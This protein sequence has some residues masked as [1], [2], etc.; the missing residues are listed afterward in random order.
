[1]LGATG[2][3]H[4]VGEVVGLDFADLCTCLN[5]AARTCLAEC[6]CGTLSCVKSQYRRYQNGRG[7]LPLLYLY[8]GSVI[9]AMHCYI[10]SGVLETV[11]LQIRKDVKNHLKILGNNNVILVIP[12][13]SYTKISLFSASRAETLQPL[14]KTMSK[15]LNKDGLVHLLFSHVI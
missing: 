12:R 3:T 5:I 1:M 15:G 13:I 2:W 7:S 4:E 11:N 6:C 14:Q 9:N 8:R 10:C